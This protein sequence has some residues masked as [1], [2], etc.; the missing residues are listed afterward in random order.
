MNSIR[1]KL[2]KRNQKNTKN[3][4]HY[5]L[6]KKDRKLLAPRYS[7]PNRPT[8]EPPNHATTNTPT[9]DRSPHPKAGRGD[10]RREG[11]PLVKG[12]V[13][14][15]ANLLPQARKKRTP[16]PR[17]WSANRRQGRRGRR[18]GRTT[19]IREGGGISFQCLF[20]SFLKGE[21][22]RHPKKGGGQAAPPN[23]K[24]EGKQHQRKG[25]PT[26]RWR[27]F[28]EKTESQKTSTFRKWATMPIF[29]KATTNASCHVGTGG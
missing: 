26:T 15:V 9:P 17:E 18:G 4:N 16:N 25:P 8:T 19:V 14:E 6:P 29:G 28:S 23:R 27:Q 20:I 3:E 7:P 13:R 1:E 11:P 21:R 10:R 12:C 24:E 22:L 5:S 2:N